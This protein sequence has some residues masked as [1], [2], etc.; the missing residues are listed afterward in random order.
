MQFCRVVKDGSRSCFSSHAAS[1]DTH[2][3]KVKPWIEMWWVRT[4]VSMFLSAPTSQLSLT[5]SGLV[6]ELIH[7]TIILS[8]PLHG[9]TGK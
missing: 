7:S 9:V 3:I 4:E 6:E 5:G 1:L 8:P 2:M